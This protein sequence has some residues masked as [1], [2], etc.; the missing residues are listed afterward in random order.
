M[1]TNTALKMP[2]F[3]TRSLPQNERE[4]VEKKNTLIAEMEQM[5]GRCK[6]ETRQMTTGEQ[7]IFDDM[8]KQANSINDQ[9]QSFS[10]PGEMKT[11]KRAGETRSSLEVRGYSKEERIGNGSADV[12]IGDL[13]Y[14]HITGKFRNDEVRAS[15]STTSGGLSIPTEVYKN[16]IDALRNESFLGETTVYPMNSQT[17]LIPR[18]TGDIVPEFKLENELSAETDPAFQSITLQGKPLYAMTSVSLELIE[19]SNLEVGQVISNIMIGAMR[20]SMQNYMLFGA[21]NGYD[22]ILNDA[23]INT[24]AATAPVTYAN[25]GA[26]VQAIRGANGQPNAVIAASDTLMGLELATDTTG[27]FITPPQFYQDLDKYAL[28]GAELGA[29]VL[30]AD[31]SAIA[32][33]VLSEGG[34]QIEIDKYGEAFQRGQIKIRARINSDFKLTNPK[35][36]AHVN[37]P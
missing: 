12:T 19:S 11:A 5:I 10:N 8:K 37:V 29:D 7:K 22:G 36:V 30:V 33:G 25:I 31:L 27:Q 20:N 2:L 16:F 21:L 6:K 15:L 18:V 13:I 34:L 9:L 35:L 1:N 3:E 14:S 23:G 28:N 24:V 4:L 26:G 32:W 17:L